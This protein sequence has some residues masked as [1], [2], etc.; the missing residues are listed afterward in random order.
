MRKLPVLGGT[1]D[2]LRTMRRGSVNFSVKEVNIEV[3]PKRVFN[4]HT[5][6]LIINLNDFQYSKK[7]SRQGKDKGSRLTH[8]ICFRRLLFNK[9]PHKQFETALLHFPLIEL[10]IAFDY[11]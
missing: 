9:K 1:W 5:E 2:Q 10:H 4:R 8:D 6:Y 3:W 7:L 11:N